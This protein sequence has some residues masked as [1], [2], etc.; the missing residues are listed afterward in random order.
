MKNRSF[1]SF[2]SLLSWIL[3]NLSGNLQSKILTHD[4]EMSCSHYIPVTNPEAIPTG[5]IAPVAGTPFD[6]TTKNN[7]AEGVL[8]CIG[9][10]KVGIDHCYV[11]DGALDAEGK[12]L[13]DFLLL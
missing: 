13:T 11:V 12:T 1:L 3:G 10:G 5:E 8:H 4:L 9:G 2:V 7:V 6:F